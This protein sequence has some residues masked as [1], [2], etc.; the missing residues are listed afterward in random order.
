M[1]NIFPKE[2]LENTTH[3]HQFKHRKKSSVIYTTLLTMLIVTLTFLPIIKVDVYTSSKGIIKPKK[4]RVSLTL[5]SSGKVLKSNIEVN[6]HVNKGDTLLVLDD[7]NIESKLTLIRFKIEETKRYIH[8]AQYLIKGVKI[9]PESL[10]SKIYQKEYLQYFQKLKELQTRNKKIKRD[11]LRN[12]QLFT[13]GVIAA[14]TFENS[15]FDYD[16][17]ISS[18]SQLRNDQYSSWQADLTGNKIQLKELENKYQLLN[19]S[20]EHFILTAPIK[21]TLVNVI[22]IEE[23]SLLVSGVPLAEISP[24]GN[25]VVECYLSPADIGLLNNESNVKFQ[26]EAFNYN[27]WGF[28]SGKILEIG[29]DVE[30]I[31]ETPVFKVRCT[32]DQSYLTL[33]NNYKG[34]LNKGMTLNARF[35]ITERTLF[36]LLYDNVDDWL[37]PGNQMTN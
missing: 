30:Y 33:K 23:G 20:K 14:V 2:I 17:A 18:L 16:L 11:Y 36:E 37:N 7:H 1:K 8:D 10:Q 22:G 3:V 25:L 4:E 6:R 13:K 28:A 9:Y 35:K 32:I 34:Y 27:Q 15:K 31:N 5:I 29:K 21:G 19:E 26:I 24:D 12:Q